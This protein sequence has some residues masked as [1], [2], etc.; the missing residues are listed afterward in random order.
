MCQQTLFCRESLEIASKVLTAEDLKKF[1]RKGVALGEDKNGVC[2]ASEKTG[3]K[4]SFSPKNVIDRLALMRLDATL[5]WLHHRKG[6]INMR[7]EERTNN[8]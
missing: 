3:T 5:T 8:A 6:G 7:S 2:Q 4:R 1:E